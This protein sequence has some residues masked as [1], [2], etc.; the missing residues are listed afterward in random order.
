M[1]SKKE[2]IALQY[3]IVR[4]YKPQLVTFKTEKIIRHKKSVEEYSEDA[5]TNHG[6]EFPNKPQLSKNA[7]FNCIEG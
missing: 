7:N 3:L 5:L 1:K 4:G 2:Q 6:G